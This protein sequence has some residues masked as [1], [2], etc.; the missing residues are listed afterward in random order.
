MSKTVLITPAWQVSIWNNVARLSESLAEA[1]SILGKDVVVITPQIKGGA[2]KR[3]TDCIHVMEVQDAIKGDW[4]KNAVQALQGIRNIDEVVLVD[5]CAWYA[6]RDILHDRSIPI[7]GVALF[8]QGVQGEKIAS[9]KTESVIE[10][11]NDF[12]CNVDKL[13]VNNEVLRER[14]KTVFNREADKL[15]MSASYA[16]ETEALLNNGSAIKKDGLVTVVGKISPELGVEKVIRAMVDLPWLKLKVIGM[17]RSDW[18][19]KRMTFLVSRLEIDA[20]RVEFMGWART[21]DVL[22]AIR[23]SELVVAPALVEY[24]GYAAMD[25]MLMKT[26]LIASTAN[27]HLELLDDSVNGLLF[28][29]QDELKYALSVMHG[30]KE[31][32]EANAEAAFTDVSDNRSIEVMARSLASLV[33]V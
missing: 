33:D 23:A 6:V 21:R 5:S 17:P 29:N 11:E 22:M 20:S 24:F 18:E 7:L 32:R 16:P 28:Q 3:I 19:M 25:A 4:K 2:R 1:L 31:L 14:I 8:G 30:S 15:E 26:S 12:I 10:E 9:V 13:L 27:V